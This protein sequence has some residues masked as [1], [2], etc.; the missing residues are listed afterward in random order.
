MMQSVLLILRHC[1]DVTWRLIDKFLIQICR[2]KTS[3]KK[4]ESETFF[5]IAYKKVFLVR[6]LKY[7]SQLTYLIQFSI[8]VR[9]FVQVNFKYFMWPPPHFLSSMLS[10]WLSFNPLLCKARSIFCHFANKA[11]LRFFLC[12]QKTDLNKVT[13]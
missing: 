7:S 2:H 12:T 6:K 10:F 4:G 5:P 13:K 1:N 3:F 11:R 8:V 9:K